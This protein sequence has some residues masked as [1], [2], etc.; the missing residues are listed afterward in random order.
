MRVINALSG[1]EV[2]VDALFPDERVGVAMQRIASVLEQPVYMWCE[3]ALTPYECLGIL[4]ETV[5]WDAQDERFPASQLSAPGIKYEGTGNVTRL[6]VISFFKN[7]RITETISCSFRYIVV[8]G[9]FADHGVD[10]TKGIPRKFDTTA[11]GVYDSSQVLLE[12]FQTE[13]FYVITKS[14][15]QGMRP[16]NIPPPAWEEAISRYRFVEPDDIH[17]DFS[18]RYKEL[19]NGK[20]DSFETQPSLTYCKF[21]GRSMFLKKGIDILV[22]YF[23]DAEASPEIPF[24]RLGNHSMGTVISRVHESMIDSKELER[25]FVS[26]K[27]NFLQILLKIPD[28]TNYAFLEVFPDKYFL[29]SRFSNQER[30]TTDVVM[31]VFPF[32]NKVLND[33]SPYFVPISEG[34]FYSDYVDHSLKLSEYRATMIDMWYSVQLNSA[35][36]YCDIRNLY[37]MASDGAVVLI[38]VNVSNDERKVFLQY[39]RSNAISKEALVIN[40]VQQNRGTSQPV[41][42]RKITS[43]YGMSSEQ[44]SR[45]LEELQDPNFSMRPK[46]PTVRIDLQSSSRLIIRSEGIQDIRHVERITLCL[47]TLFDE[48]LS[49]RKGRS[50]RQPISK[51]D[52]IRTMSDKVMSKVGEIDEF[53]DIVNISESGYQEVGV[54]DE[55]EEVFNMGSDVLRALQVRDPEVFGFRAQNVF[56]PYSVQCQDRQPVALTDE[57]YEKAKSG[58]TQGS[59]KGEIRY[60]SKNQYNFICPQKWCAT[61][62]V[63]RKVGE[64]C[65]KK[66]EPVWDF[67]QMTYPGFLSGAKHPKGLCMPCCFKKE[68]KPGGK[69]YE[70]MGECVGADMSTDGSKASHL[71]RSS[72]I[73][74]SGVFGKVSDALASHLPANVVRR[75]MGTKVGF[76]DVVEFV[77]EEVGFLD[78]FQKEMEYHHFLSGTPRNIPPGE[79]SKSDFFEW[80]SS[81]KSQEYRNT[82]SMKPRLADNQIPREMRSYSSFKNVV[83]SPKDSHEKWVRSINAFTPV[84]LPHIIVLNDNGDFATVTVDEIRKDRKKVVIIQQ[85]NDRYEP[86]G[87]LDKNMFGFV[88]D[89]SLPYVTKFLK[90]QIISVPIDGTRVLST[91]GEVIA[92]ADG[93]QILALPKPV[94]FVPGYRHVHLSDLPKKITVGH[95][96]AK[97][98]LTTTR[99]DFFKN[100]Y[101]QKTQNLIDD[102]DNDLK[103]FLGSKDTDTRFSVLKDLKKKSS[104]E[105]KHSYDVWNVVSNDPIM[106]SRSVDTG[107]KIKII[108]KKYSTKLPKIPGEVLDYILE[109]LMRPTSVSTIPIVKKGDEEVIFSSTK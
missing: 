105:A 45:L 103:I 23:A 16:S 29:S 62:G 6:D 79:I 47:Q 10:P 73:L 15:M 59:F 25:Y 90:K 36:K 31:K 97:K 93:A 102:Q 34:V 64:A 54:E 55:L 13:T 98:A 75:G 69:V 92:I 77:F 2:K 60:G 30:L 46:V 51:F 109:R 8:G 11:H 48:C 28:T 76:F 41:L 106:K 100:D 72:R 22:T 17:D 35:K 40:F 96:S 78:R 9:Y 85:S 56:R 107:K 99:N 80:W 43:D 38:P 39:V 82:F 44:G 61:S 14:D 63:A 27:K 18:Y 108:R 70:R 26:K 21:V 94:P 32:V 87:I 95:R 81:P 20:P 53:I 33:I 37:S 88:F 7:K 68:P 52:V 101:I 50:I 58:S 3:R 66:D 91:T 57:E 84:D 86:L 1:K 19:L 12:S 67:G 24:I 5:G 104:L 83:L 49:G 74:D 89:V 65:P 42:L 71:S 4:V